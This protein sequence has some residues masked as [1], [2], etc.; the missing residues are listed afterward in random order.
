[1]SDVL[2]S[3]NDGAAKRAFVDFVTSATQP[4]PGFVQSLSSR[5]R[6]LVVEFSETPE[7]SPRF[8]RHLAAESVCGSGPL[9]SSP[10]LTMFDTS[11]AIVPRSALSPLAISPVVLRGCSLTYPM[12]RPSMSSLC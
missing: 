5:L 4:G 2:A 12:M 3:W 11:A 6:H 7:R 1:M 9:V 8:G 10:A